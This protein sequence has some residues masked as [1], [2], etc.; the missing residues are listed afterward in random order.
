MLCP[1]HMGLFSTNSRNYLVYL[2]L[3]PF[4][5]CSSCPKPDK[6]NW[7]SGLVVYETWI[8]THFL[9]FLLPSQI[10][11]KQHACILLLW[12]SIHL[13]LGVMTRVMP[14]AGIVC[15]M[16]GDMPNV[17]YCWRHI[18]MYFPF[19]SIKAG[20]VNSCCSSESEKAWSLLT[21]KYASFL[22]WV[23]KNDSLLHE[24]EGSPSSLLPSLQEAGS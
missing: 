19:F 5:I 20:M 12:L 1:E 17:R 18:S 24:G 3:Q 23:M 13:I 11:G 4:P 15:P 10:A 6:Y 8:V 9:S 7:Y 16:N 2:S 22:F 21:Y 14:S